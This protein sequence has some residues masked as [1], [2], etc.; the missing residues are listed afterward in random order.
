MNIKSE[1][2][3]NIFQRLLTLLLMNKYGYQMCNSG[4]NKL[5]INVHTYIT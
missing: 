1:V 2:S 5:I 3:M 4:G